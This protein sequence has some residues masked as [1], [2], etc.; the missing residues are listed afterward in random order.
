[1]TNGYV[2]HLAERLVAEVGGLLV[3]SGGDVDVHE[4]IGDVAFFGYEGYTARGRGRWI[5]MK[6]DCHEWTVRVT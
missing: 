4:L 2:W 5:T 6:F 3:L 1:M